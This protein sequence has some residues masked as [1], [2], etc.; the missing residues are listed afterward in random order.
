MQTAQQYQ[1]FDRAATAVSPATCI[2]TL[3]FEQQYNGQ[4]YRTSLNNRLLVVGNKLNSVS[5]NSITESL[6][7]AQIPFYYITKI[8]SD[9]ASGLYRLDVSLYSINNAVKATAIIND[10]STRIS[11]E[12]AKLKDLI[13]D[14]STQLNQYKIEVDN[15]F[16]K[17]I[18]GTMSG[19][20]AFTKKTTTDKSV[21]TT[22]PGI[23]SNGD[24]L[25]LACPNGYIS[26]WGAMSEEYNMNNP[27]VTINKPTTQ[28][29][30]KV[31]VY[32]HASQQMVWSM[33]N[34]G[35]LSYSTADYSKYY[36]LGI[37]Q[38]SYEE[39]DFGEESYIATEGNIETNVYVHRKNVYANAF[40]ASSD[41]ALKYDV[42]PIDIST[43]IPDV[44]QFRWYDTSELSYGFIAQDLEEHG[45][46]YLMDKDDEDHWRV[47]YN[48][49]LALVVGDLQQKSKVQAQEIKDLKESNQ[50]LIE[51]ITKLEQIINNNGI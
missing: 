40:Y 4:V 44:I 5:K 12:D 22:A 15:N 47:N 18:G 49:A 7:Q 14:V 9:T 2:E 16:L 24:N 38:Q 48:A 20:I 26:L 19:G 3:Y 37:T 23:L 31:L 13:F 30:G 27:G 1:M 29:N 46:Q 42:Q 35:S 6:N 45:L 34:A 28:E 39:R 51:R 11:E 8:K 17:L 33:Y 32:N 10:I 41:I 43:Y 50:M 36:I 21:I 25:I